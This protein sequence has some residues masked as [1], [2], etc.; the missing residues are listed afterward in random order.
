[1]DEAECTP[2]KC[3]RRDVGEGVMYVSPANSARPSVELNKA[4]LKADGLD[5]KTE[6]KKLRHLMVAAREIVVSRVEDTEKAPPELQF[7]ASTATNGAK[8]I[9]KVL[10]QLLEVAGVTTVEKVQIKRRGMIGK[11]NRVVFIRSV[12]ARG[13]GHAGNQAYK[14]QSAR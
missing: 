10:G 9:L 3:A 13:A 6:V 11:E 14:R 1:M 12:A 4:V 8:V 5:V 2:E 7:M